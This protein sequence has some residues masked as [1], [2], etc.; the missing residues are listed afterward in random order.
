MAPSP[1]RIARSGALYTAGSARFQRGRTRAVAGMA[2]R[3][4]APAEPAPSQ[5]FR[6][7]AAFSARS[8]SMTAP[9]L[10][11]ALVHQRE[12]DARCAGATTPTPA[13]TLHAGITRVEALDH[14]AEALLVDVREQYRELVAAEPPDEVGFAQ[15]AR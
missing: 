10:G 3:H 8:A 5:A 11:A 9:E 1:E 7:L 13:S 12:A 4:E 6:R 2:R 15:P 14:D